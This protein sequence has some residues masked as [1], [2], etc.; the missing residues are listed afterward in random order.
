[1]RGAA[2]KGLKMW[3]KRHFPTTWA[4][5]NVL[6]DFV[7]LFMALGGPPKMMLVEDIHA[8]R[9][10][11]LYIW[12][13]QADLLDAFPGFV[14]ADSPPKTVILLAGNRTS[15]AAAFET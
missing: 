14:A 8:P 3:V 11:T 10:S 2:Q 12:L 1:M 6:D 4:T 9:N 7:Q 5:G 13:P 15:F